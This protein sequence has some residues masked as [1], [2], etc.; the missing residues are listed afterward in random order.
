MQYTVNH[1]NEEIVVLDVTISKTELEEAMAKAK[2]MLQNADEKTVRQYALNYEISKAIEEEFVKTR[3]KLATEPEIEEKENENGD[4]EARVT[5]TL[6]PAIEVGQYTNFQL[7]K[8][9]VDVK[10]EEVLAEAQKQIAAHPVWEETDQPATSG[11]QVIIDFVGK[12]DGTVFEGGSGTDYPLV[13]GSGAFIP[14]FETQLIGIRKGEQ[15]AV[16]VTFPADYFE[17]SLAGAPV[18][19]DVT[20]KAVQ[21]AVEPQLTD[22]FVA[23][24]GH[25][26]IKTVEQLKETVKNH[27]V[28]V[29]EREADDKLA[30]AI[31]EKVMAQV[32]VRVPQKMI[33]NQ[34]AQRLSQLQNQIQQYGMTMEQYLKMSGQE[35][36]ALKAQLVP[37][38]TQEIKQ[39]LVLDAIAQ[40]EQIKADEKELQAE[41]E[42]L[43]RVYQMPA[44]QLVQMIPAP[45]VATQIAQRKTMDFLKDHNMEGD[46]AG[47]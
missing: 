16:E 43:A 29:K 41:Y 35:L 23:K 31:L 14:G 42:L 36:D 24:L 5:C 7:E 27:L 30:A 39:A 9:I 37:M 11:S 12:K 26:Q 47:Q 34:V 2:E 1:R 22:A 15:K 3:S 33:D 8:Q 32:E 19:F 6:I 28:S 44:S 25:E 45:A 10:E 17:K 21:E 38:A 18:V 13:L 46:K 4:I 20:C 40:K